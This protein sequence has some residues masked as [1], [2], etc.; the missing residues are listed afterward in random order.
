MADEAQTYWCCNDGPC[1]PKVHPDYPRYKNVTC[2]GRKQFL[3]ETCHSKCNYIPKKT[4]CDDVIASYAKA[5]GENSTTCVQEWGFHNG[6]R[7]AYPRLC[8][9]DVLCENSNDL[10]WC[11]DS[12]RSNEGCGAYRVNRTPYLHTYTVQR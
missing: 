11:R 4:D 5:C 10:K 6:G 3:N 1:V 8:Q 7:I 9:G 2:Q 12:Q